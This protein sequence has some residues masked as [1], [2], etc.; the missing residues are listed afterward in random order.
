MAITTS[1]IS[2]ANDSDFPIQNIPFG[3]IQKSNGI[4]VAASIIGDYVIDLHAL[5]RL[6]YFKNILDAENAYFKQ[7]NQIKNGEI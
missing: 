3:I 4:T 1:W 6:G 5:H 2:V 7:L